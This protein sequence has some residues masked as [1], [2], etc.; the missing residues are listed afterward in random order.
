MQLDHIAVSGSTLE[1]AIAHVEQAL[2]VSLQPGGKHAKFGT[3][4]RLL[5]L[6]DG[7]YL[8]AIAVDPDA[9]APE[10]P[11]WFDLDRF[12]GPARLTN[13]ICRV[14]DIDAITMPDGPVTPIDLDRGALRWR[15]AVPASGRLPY[16]NL[17]PALIQ[18]QGDLHPARMLQSSGVRLRRLIVYHPDAL[19]LAKLLGQ[20]KLIEFDTGPAAIRAEFETP[21]GVRTLE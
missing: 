9:P 16:D 6:E 17:Y 19:E 1:A 21:W 3:Y 11:R 8:E 14:S 7:L 18:W 5:G 13:W 4:N 2:G 10:Q 20:I 12:S 15:M